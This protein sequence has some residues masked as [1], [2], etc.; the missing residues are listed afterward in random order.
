MPYNTKLCQVGDDER[1]NGLFAM[2]VAHY[3]RKLIQI[4]ADL[5]YDVNIMERDIIPI[6]RQ[7]WEKL[8]RDVANNKEAFT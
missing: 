4:K 5:C 3:K 1:L 2:E 7:A 8:F 6:V